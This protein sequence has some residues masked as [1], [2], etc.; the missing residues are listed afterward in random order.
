MRPVK[1]NI[2]KLPEPCRQ[3]M[4]DFY[5]VTE[6]GEV[7]G[8]RL[9]DIAKHIAMR[10]ELRVVKGWIRRETFQAFADAFGCTPAE[11]H[12]A[13]ARTRDPGREDGF[14]SDIKS[15]LKYCV[16]PITGEPVQIDETAMT[17]IWKYVRAQVRTLMQE[18]LRASAT[19]GGKLSWS[20]WEC[21]AQRHNFKPQKPLNPAMQEA[22][23]KPHLE[24]VELVKQWKQR[25]KQEGQ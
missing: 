1:I 10:P 3:P 11:F 16:D 13:L 22:E 9:V 2:S 17:V 8:P 6:T 15:V 24:R 21:V 19:N 4:L 5:G 23:R 12:E 20:C 18:L 7:M 14:F 25:K